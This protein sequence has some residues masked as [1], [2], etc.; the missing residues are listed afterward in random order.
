MAIIA[1]SY[2]MSHDLS[3]WSQA[4]SGYNL[5][6]P[7]LSGN[8]TQQFYQYYRDEASTCNSGSSPSGCAFTYL[9][10]SNDGSLAGTGPYTIESVSQSTNNI[11]M[12]ANP[13]Y[14]GGPYQA[15]NG[16]NII[17]T[18][19]TI[20]INYVPQLSTREIDLKSNAA[21]NKAFMIDLPGDNLFDVA[22]RNSWLNNNE[23]VSTVPGVSL[24]V[25]IHS[26][27][28]S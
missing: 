10:G 9:F 27:L 23:I 3:M 14:W 11:V 20:N 15:I 5:P 25:R 4:S 1:P 7:T 19:K 28:Q 26:L 8:A 18:I 2:V 16:T 24:M 21:S 6:F 12:Q 22:D 17:P 13:K